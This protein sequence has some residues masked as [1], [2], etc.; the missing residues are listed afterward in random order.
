MENFAG[1]FV[2][3]VWDIIP[4]FLLLFLITGILF[5]NY[6]RIKREEELAVLKQIA[7]ILY[8]LNYRENNQY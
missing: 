5:F 2:S 7:Q 8:E 1:H 3:V 4:I 6:Y